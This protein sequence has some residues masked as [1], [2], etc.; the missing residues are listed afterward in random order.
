[1]QKIINQFLVLLLAFFLA[2][3]LLSQIPFVSRDSMEKLSKKTEKKLGDLIVKS[4]ES[5]GQKIY[6]AP[7]SQILDSIKQKICSRNSFDSLNI[8]IHVID[9]TDINAFALPGDNLVI[10]SG[11]INYAKNADELAGVMAHEIAHI[12]KNH[13]TKKLLK[14]IGLAMLMTIAGGDAGPEIA[15]EVLRTLSSTGF[16]RKQE[17]EA[18]KIAAE[19]MAKAGFDPTSLANFFFRL[20]QSDGNLPAGLEWITTH[21]DTNDRAAE[22]LEIKKNLAFKPEV[23]IHTPWDDVKKLLE[24]DSK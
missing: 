8:K 24:N 14:E 11:L 5:Q 22:I 1:M 9:K 23:C 16:D 7:L 13:V 21:P 10:Y 4:L 20:A 19:S 17:R 18:D 12:E 15:K 2:W 6:S 3:F